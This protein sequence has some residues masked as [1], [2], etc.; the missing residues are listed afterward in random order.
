[1]FQVQLSAEDVEFYRSIALQ[2]EREAA[3]WMRVVDALQDYV[4]EFVPVFQPG[5]VDLTGDALTDALEDAV[6]SVRAE[7]AERLREVGA[8]TSTE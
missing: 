3:A 2:R 8:L 6:A 1:M 4:R 5:G 7:K